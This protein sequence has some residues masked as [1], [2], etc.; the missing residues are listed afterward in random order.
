MWQSYC[1]HNTWQTCGMTP[2]LSA[3]CP[4]LPEA[5]SSVPPRGWNIS[6]PSLQNVKAYYVQLLWPLSLTGR[7]Y[8]NLFVRPPVQ[9]SGRT[10]QARKLLFNIWTKKWT[11]TYLYVQTLSI[12]HVSMCVSLIWHP[13]QSLRVRVLLEGERGCVVQSSDLDLEE[14]M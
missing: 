13:G 8:W 11:Q 6:A 7:Q 14:G 12:L 4:A 3:C 2:S 9:C 10:E 1:E 5:S